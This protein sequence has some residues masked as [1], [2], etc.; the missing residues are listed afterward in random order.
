MNNVIE[1]NSLDMRYNGN[2][3]IKGLSL[4]VSEGSVYAFLGRNGAGKTTTIKALLGLLDPAGGTVRVLGSDPAHETKS[5][6]QEI[7]YVSEDRALY[8][9]M[10]AGEMIRFTAAF[11][12]NWDHSLA[13][14]LAVRLKIKEEVKISKMSRGQKGKLCLLVALAHKPRLLLLDEP[15]AGLDSVV[16]RQFIEETIE[17]ISEEGRT[18]L[19]STH[20]INEVE[21][22]ADWVGIL[23]GGSLALDTRLQDLKDNVRRVRVFRVPEGNE[24]KL[25]EGSLN[26]H[27]HDGDLSFISTIVSPGMTSDLKKQGAHKVEIEDMS[28]DDIFVEL[29]R[30]EEY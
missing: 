6:M 10:T 20:L 23:T 28:L 16:R 17:L 5:I 18:V 29:T 26:C 2:S 7:G 25:P 15:T 4:S 27:R 13:G 24:I 19:F 9:W 14:E 3:V 22:V 30:E 12:H 1:I 8:E 11:Y 21:R